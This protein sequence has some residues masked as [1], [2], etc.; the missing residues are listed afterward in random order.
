MHADLYIGN[1]CVIVPA[2][3][4]SSFLTY[5]QTYK[6]TKLYLVPPVIVRLVKDSLTESYN[7]SSLQQIISGAAPLGSD[8]MA[9]LRSKF[10]NIIFKQCTLPTI[11]SR[12]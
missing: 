9:L 11:G 4:F 6:M 8:T 5:I 12:N 10:K 1:T 3:E 2:F 7:L